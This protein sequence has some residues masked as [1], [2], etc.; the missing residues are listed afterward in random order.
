MIKVIKNIAFTSTLLFLFSAC[1]QFQEKSIEVLY[2]TDLEEFVNPERRFYRPIGTMTSAFR[3]LDA[4]RLLKLREPSPAAGGFDVGSSLTY[5]SYQFDT[6]KDKLLTEEILANIQTDMDIIREVGNKMIL[7]F[8][9]SNRCCD[10]PFND[11]PKAIILQHLDQLRPVITKNIDVIAV[12][13]MGLIGPWGE[14]F[15]SDHFGDLEHGPVTDQH[16]LDRAEVI[17]KLLD[18]VPESRMVQVRAP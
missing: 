6:F 3:P 18:V 13:Q 14:Q 7:R 1:S 4:E 9:Y 15:Y 16:W 5:R 12:V 8:T 17:S 11:A 2:Q 10:P